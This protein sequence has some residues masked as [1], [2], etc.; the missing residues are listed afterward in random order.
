MTIIKF[1]ENPS[2]EPPFFSDIRKDGY[3]IYSLKNAKKRGFYPSEIPDYPGV[4][5]KDLKEDDTIT[6]RVFF[7]IGKGKDMRVDGGHLDLRVEL[8]EEGN[9]FAVITTQ[10]P[11]ELSLSTGDSLELFPEEI[12][13]KQEPKK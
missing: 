2:K 6:I 5:L 12:L 13:Y 3:H 1:P 10:L 9:I 11:K 4:L 7:G 8:V